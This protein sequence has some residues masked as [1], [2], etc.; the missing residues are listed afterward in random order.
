MWLLSR[1]QSLSVTL[2]VNFV[3]FIKHHNGLNTQFRG[4]ILFAVE[5]D[6]ELEGK[7][8]SS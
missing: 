2:S 8:A 7:M 4:V 5:Q 1:S 6:Y 3:L